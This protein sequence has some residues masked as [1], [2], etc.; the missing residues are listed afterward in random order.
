M[1]ESIVN[2]VAILRIWTGDGN[3][4]KQRWVRYAFSLA[5]MLQG[6]V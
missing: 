5:W 1:I 4:T 3:E 2:S 6:N